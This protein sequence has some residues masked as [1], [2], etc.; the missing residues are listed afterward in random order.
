MFVLW[1]RCVRIFDAARR[2]VPAV[3]HGLIHLSVFI[4]LFRRFPGF[5]RLGK[6]NPKKHFGQRPLASASNFLLSWS[7]NV[8]ALS[9]PPRRG[10]NLLLHLPAP[11]P[12]RSVIH[13][14]PTSWWLRRS[15]PLRS[16][17]GSAFRGRRL[18]ERRRRRWQTG[19]L[20]EIALQPPWSRGEKEQT[21]Y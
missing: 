4:H 2:S 18:S 17:A 5:I 1:R 10:I 13:L 8:C 21:G 19:Q 15:P 3:V 14:I 20:E 16:G 12:S 7:L 11:L 6:K 9:L